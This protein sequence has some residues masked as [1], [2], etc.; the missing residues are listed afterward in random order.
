M[1]ENVSAVFLFSISPYTQ[2]TLISRQLAEWAQYNFSFWFFCC[3]F[4]WKLLTL[5]GVCPWQSL[6]PDLL[7]KF[8]SLLKCRIILYLSRNIFQTVAMVHH[9][10]VFCKLI[11]YWV[12][13][14][15]YLKRRNFLKTE[16]M[17]KFPNRGVN[18][19]VY[20]VKSVFTRQLL[21]K[22]CCLM[23]S[24]MS[25]AHPAWYNIAKSK[26]LPFIRFEEKRMWTIFDLPRMLSFIDFCESLTVEPSC[27]LGEK[28]PLNV[29]FETCI[30][31][32]HR[33]KAVHRKIWVKTWRN[34]VLRFILALCE[35]TSVWPLKCNKAISLILFY[36][37]I[38]LYVNNINQY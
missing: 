4:L 29:I 35:A 26:I 27:A 34:F 36:I 11:C 15:M 7:S 18:I 22:M 21:W 24:M 20:P 8:H 25:Y 30:R 28:H 33:Q 13:E 23:R 17:K 10:R 5:V 32:C 38:H 12:G 37:L 2:R 19:L 3:L 6:D 16:Y 31:Y 1:H 14:K 9:W